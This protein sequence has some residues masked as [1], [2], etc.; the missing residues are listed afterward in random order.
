M[1]RFHTPV[2]L[3]EGVAGLT[4]KLNEKY[5]DATV[6]DGG[7]AE[8]IDKRSGIV[9]GI[10][11]DRDA[12]QRAGDRLKG[13]N[14]TLVHANFRDLETVAK[15]RG[16]GTVAGIIFDL[17][18]SSNQLDSPERGFS[19]RFP[20]AI[21]DMRYDSSSGEPAGELINRLSE[22]ELYEIFAE[23]GEEERARSIARAVVRA[24]RLKPITIAG[25]L[26]EI[27]RSAV[28]GPIMLRRSLPRVFQSLRIAVNDELGALKSGLL[29][30]ERLLKP[31][32]RLAVV[33]FHSLEDRT[34]K[35]F[36]RRPQWAMITKKPT[37]PGSNE[38]RANP[39][40]RSAK[41][42]VAQKI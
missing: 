32:G 3:D 14:V 16:F 8:Q 35:L 37:R 39:R 27:V 31:G 19:F 29:G 36:M 24:R 28:A 4:V 9:L 6:G 25:D 10:D 42:R 38:I 20:N 41:L 13:R 23:F 18:V 33:S 1:N 40:S 22:V 30:A 11:R 7:L 21:L 17:G 12:I 5:I 26:V 15:A 34:V 2:L